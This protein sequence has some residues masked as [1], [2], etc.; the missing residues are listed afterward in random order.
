MEDY[1]SIYNN[2]DDSTDKGNDFY[3]I[4]TKN[5]KIKAYDIPSKCFF[6]D[7]EDDEYNEIKNTNFGII[8]KYS[9][10]RGV[11]N[12]KEPPLLRKNSILIYKNKLNNKNKR[13]YRNKSEIKEE[14]DYFRIN[15]NS[16]KV[17]FLKSH[18]I[19]YIDVESYKKYYYDNYKDFYSDNKLLG[20][21]ESK[22]CK[23]F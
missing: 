23:I 4:K 12:T 5:K 16:K 2:K 10:K 22:C 13:R 21:A 20:G 3:K 6:S 15:K 18:F 8:N 9:N 14:K 1:N 7:D 11:I 19:E 17:T